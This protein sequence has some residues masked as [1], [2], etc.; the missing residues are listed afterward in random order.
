MNRYQAILATQSGREVEML[1]RDATGHH[2]TRVQCTLEVGELVHSHPTDPR[3][4]NV[5]AAGWQFDLTARCA[6]GEAGYCWECPD[7]GPGDQA[8]AST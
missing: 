7:E 4:N 6:H 3:G 5:R 8:K 1:S 2:H